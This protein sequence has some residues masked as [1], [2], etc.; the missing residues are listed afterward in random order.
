MNENCSYFYK[1]ICETDDYFKDLESQEL[2]KQMDT[3]IEAY[4]KT[5]SLKDASEHAGVSYDTVQY[6]Y[7]WGSMGIGEEN[8]YFYDKIK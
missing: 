6:W 8:S 3:V 4:R 7:K 2:K 1:G 5:G